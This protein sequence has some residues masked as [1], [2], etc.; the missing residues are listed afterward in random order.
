MKKKKERFLSFWTPRAS[1]VFPV[2]KTNKLLPETAF[3]REETPFF[4]CHYGG[5]YDNAFLEIII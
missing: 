2:L 5:A 1:L 4:N 3:S